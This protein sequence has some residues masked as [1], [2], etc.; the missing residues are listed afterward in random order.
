ME[1]IKYKRPLEEG[2]WTIND[3][4]LSLLGH[5]CTSCGEVFFPRRKRSHCAHCFRRTLE[6][7][8]LGPEGKITSF[9]I[10][11]I[12]P[13]GGFYRGHVPYAYGCVDLPAGVRIKSLMARDDIGVL[14]VGMLVTLSTEVL[15]E[16]DEGIPV[17]TFV[18]K[19]LKEK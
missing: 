19:Q 7:I 9:S 17:E 13:A 3:V 18:F 10:V 14:K 8:N 11:M 12:A 2:L 16:S 1:S 15:Y 6:E 4:S 5:R